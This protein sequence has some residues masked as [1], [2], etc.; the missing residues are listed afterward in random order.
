M[1]TTTLTP[2]QPT[3]R[4]GSKAH[5]SMSE[6]L[7]GHRNSLGL[8]RLVLAI[9]VIFSHAFPLG[10]WGEDPIQE[11]VKSQDNL[12]GIAVVGFFAISGY[13]VTKSGTSNDVI[14]FLW[15]R[16]LRIFPAFFVVLLLT[17]FVVGPLLWHAEGHP[18]SSYLGT[19]PGSPIAYLANWR[20]KIG[21]WGIYDLALHTPYGQLVHYSALNGSIWTLFYEFQCYLMIAALVLFGVLRRARI[22][23]PILT[24]VFAVAEIS[25]TLGVNPRTLSPVLADPLFVRLGFVFLLGACFA[26]YSRQVVFD[27]WIA[28]FCICVTILSLREG[29]WTVFGY[30]AFAYLMLWLA[31]RLPRSTQFIGTKN[32]YS[33]GIYIYAFLVQQVTATFGWYRWGYL[34]W[35]FACLAIT[36]GCAWIS[37][38]GLEKRALALKNWGPGRGA[39]HWYERITAGR[40]RRAIAH[41]FG[42]PMSLSHG[43]PGRDEPGT[44]H[45]DVLTDHSA[46]EQKPHSPQGV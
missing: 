17:A 1:M 16:V 14:Q 30:P 37:W 38:H 25:L 11:H 35:T 4:L 21:Q 31:A 41:G 10:G 34:P 6:A 29:G 22:L 46:R 43:T 44:P 23:V 18:F 28:V 39:R 42:E 19:G 7:G 40:S 45:I 12:G 32:D 27:D 20:L 5:I 3:S 13:L 15:H 8:I 36:A 2:V 9:I 26:V 33:Y 24:G